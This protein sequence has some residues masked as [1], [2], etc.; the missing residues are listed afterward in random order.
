[1]PVSEDLLP[2]PTELPPSLV[3]VEKRI[4]EVTEEI[5]RLEKEGSLSCQP[6]EEHM[7]MT[8]VE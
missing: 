5:A 3:A 7:A 1:M 8:R 6:P 4:K 2:P